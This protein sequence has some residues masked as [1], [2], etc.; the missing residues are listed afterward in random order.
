MSTGHLQTRTRHKSRLRRTHPI[1]RR[2]TRPAQNGARQK[3]HSHA[4][5]HS[6]LRKN[7][8]R[9]QTR[10]DTCR[11]KGSNL[12]LIC[13]DTFRPGAY[14][15]LQQLAA[16]INVPI[17]GDP[18]AKDPVKVVNARAQTVP[19]QRHNHR[20]HFGAPQRRKR[21]HQRNERPRETH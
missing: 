20:G 17:Y 3:I 2:Q 10:D 6:G 11:R 7:H 1:R 9:R 14:A 4:R 5:R 21:T 12:R 18:K 19:R 15:Q 13:A 8:P 16:R